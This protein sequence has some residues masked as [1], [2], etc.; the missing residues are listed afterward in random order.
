MLTD[1]LVYRY[2]GI[3][4]KP[5]FQDDISIRRA[6]LRNLKL[7]EQ[8]LFMLA[9]NP[10]EYIAK[11]T[12]WVN[13][14]AKHVSSWIHFLSSQAGYNSLLKSVNSLMTKSLSGFL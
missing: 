12:A 2:D 9:K 14:F 10:V 4:S 1:D 13:H 8:N 7:S 5:A 6:A 11:I 3:C